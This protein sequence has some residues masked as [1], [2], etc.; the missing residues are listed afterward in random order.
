MK[1]H[2]DK[3]KEK[4]SEFA[5]EYK[6]IVSVYDNLL[7]ATQ[8]DKVIVTQSDI[9]LIG[10]VSEEDVAIEIDDTNLY[11]IK[12]ITK[13]EILSTLM[14]ELDFESTLNLDVGSVIGYKF[15]IKID[16]ET[17]E[18]EYLDYGRYIIYK[19]EFSQDT[20]LYTYTC[21]DYM[22]KSM[23]MIGDE[24][25]GTY[26]STDAA[27]K[28]V[29]DILG[30]D[31]N[32]EMVEIIDEEEPY[33]PVIPPSHLRPTPYGSMVNASY[34][35]L[36]V[37]IIK[38]NKMTYRDLLD[39]ICKLS[40]T[41]I[42]MD[43]NELKLKIL[44]TPRYISGKGW[45]LDLET[46][47]IADTFDETFMHDKNINFESVYGPMNAL[48]L[49]IQD[50]DEEVYKE[51]TES[52]T[53][54]GMTLTQITTNVIYKS[55]WDNYK[56][57]I[58]NAILYCF[59]GV[60]FNLHDIKTTGILYLDWLDY[61]NVTIGGTTYK[62]LL[63][64]SE[65]TIK[66]G[67]SEDIYTDIPENNQSEYTTSNKSTEVVADVV[68]SRGNAYANGERLVQE[69]EVTNAINDSIYSTNDIIIGKWIN[70]KSIYRKVF[71]GSFQDGK[72]L[73]Y[74]IDSLIRCFG[75]GDVGTGL[76]R[77]IPW[78]ETWD[79]KNFMLSVSIRND[80]LEVSA[81]IN[82]NA[83]ST[84]SNTEIIVDYTKK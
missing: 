6:N 40:G 24:F 56:D 7:L 17:N 13:G 1:V 71:T 8:D 32:T 29:C 45:N 23:I 12:L 14:K 73:I 61:Y 75:H 36:D 63:L 10:K 64:N 53:T 55:V 74:G 42:Y 26:I 76:G 65:I 70:G 52:V 25:T 69:S 41:N 47:D 51:D 80:N 58:V 38:S 4:I 33:P 27:L 37:S 15:G 44:G 9:E 68:R 72:I 19:K 66:N 31:L 28:K 34:S 2:S 62:C 21:Y 35:L 77:L 50:S 46:P 54:N 16:D 22:L 83:T 11:S 84:T 59:D 39:V 60:S 82:G 57:N 20:K 81:V 79:G 48:S 78:H 5:R 3:F 43:N 67:I 30:Y 18:Y 49:T